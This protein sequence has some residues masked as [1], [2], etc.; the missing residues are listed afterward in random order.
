MVKKVCTDNAVD[1][2]PP[3]QAVFWKV[4]KQS[5]GCAQRGINVNVRKK[6]EG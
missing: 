1:R 4:L 5:M 2:R 6:E 3:G